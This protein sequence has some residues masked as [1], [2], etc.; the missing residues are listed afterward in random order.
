MEISILRLVGK[1][2]RGRSYNLTLKDRVEEH[3][4][5]ITNYIYKP[6]I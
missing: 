2:P 1:W 6:F 4:L 5:I 3:N